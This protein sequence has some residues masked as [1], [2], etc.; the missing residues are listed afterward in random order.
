MIELALTILFFIS[1]YG[2]LR[3]SKMNEEEMKR[4]SSSDKEGYSKGINN[5]WD[6]K[7]NRYPPKKTKGYEMY[8]E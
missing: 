2:I 5:K 6:K 1:V 4:S 7:K 8:I 3:S